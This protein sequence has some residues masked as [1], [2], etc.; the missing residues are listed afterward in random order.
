MESVAAI[1]IVVFQF[2]FGW[3]DEESRAAHAIPPAEAEA[4]ATR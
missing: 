1:L 3:C 4:A 2:F